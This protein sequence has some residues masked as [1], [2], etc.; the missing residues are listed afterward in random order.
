MKKLTRRQQEF[1]GKL[2]DLYQ[3]EGEPIHYS[4]LAENLDVG[5]VT[6]YEMLCLLEDRGLAQAEYQRPEDRSGP[7]RSTVVFRPTALAAS[8][9]SDLAGGGWDEEEWEQAKHRVLEQLRAG[10][11]GGYETLLNDL[12]A[13][14]P[15][16][17]S[18]II[19]YLA[20]MITATVLGLHSLKDVAEAHSLMKILRNLGLPGE[21]GLSALTGFSASLS[22]VERVNRQV[23]S[24]LLKQTKKYQTVLSEMSAENQ[25]RLAEFTRE[26]V[27]IV[28]L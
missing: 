21:I 20:E 18:P 19:I 8:T 28:G 14:L 10:K 7:G 16:Q 1:L 22:L 9:F 2:L 5:K 24:V 26:V 6:A 27:K 11:V 17:R 3:Q 4:I 13:R 15:G 12:L 23:A 25:R